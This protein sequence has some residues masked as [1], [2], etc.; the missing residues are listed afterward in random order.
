MIFDIHCHY[1][2]TQERGADLPRFSFEPPAPRRAP[3]WGRDALPTHFASCVSPQALRRVAWRIAQRVLRLPS[4]GPDLDVALAA[5][6]EKHLL[7]DG[8]IER[9]VLLAFDAVL[10]DDGRVLPLPD[11]ERPGSDIYTSNSLVHALCRRRPDR[12]CFGASVHP[13]HADA[14]ERL[15]AVAAAGACLI[16][17][18]PLHHNID[19]SD[20]RTLEFMRCCAGLG[21]PLLVHTSE[22]FTLATNFP[23]HRPFRVMLAAL[24]KL[25]REDAM[26]PVIVA[27][28]ATPVTPWGERESHALLLEALEGEFADAPLF[29]DISALCAATKAKFL[30]RLARRQE[31]HHKLLFGS[32]FPVPTGVWALRWALGRAYRETAAM[33]S[34]P[35][36]AAMACRAVGFNEI[37]FHRAATVLRVAPLAATL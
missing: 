25:M 30:L 33:R 19:P 7:A 24:R 13:Y 6:Y 21:M 2:L 12:F 5:R 22:E 31:L 37:V 10:D 29:A 36:Q 9:F 27:H 3:P 32:D 18:I 35:Q 23:E 17:W 20:P 4:A 16:K 1:T 11:G 8:P 15:G 14:I 34:W 28:A 26:P